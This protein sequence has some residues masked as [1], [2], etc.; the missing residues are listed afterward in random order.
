[1]K[2]L[3]RGLQI[4]HIK[5]SQEGPLSLSKRADLD[6]EKWLSDSTRV[7][8]NYGAGRAFEGFIH[9]VFKRDETLIAVTARD[10][11]IGPEEIL[12]PYLVGFDVPTLKERFRIQTPGHVESLSWAV[13]GQLIA[14]CSGGNACS[15]EPER[16]TLSVLPI[17]AAPCCCHP[18]HD[19]CTFAIPVGTTSN[20]KYHMRVVWL[21]GLAT[22]TEQPIFGFVHDMCW[23]MDGTKL[24]AVTSAGDLWTCTFPE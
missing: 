21:D 15:I 4:W 20:E 17:Q 8:A 16:G 10:R 13:S 1:M 2:T 19:I 7:F 9:V 14:C 22:I 11:L 5:S 3:G 23:S 12:I 6:L 24:F 18:I